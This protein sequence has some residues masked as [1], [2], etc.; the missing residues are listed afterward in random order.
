MENGD[1]TDEQITYSSGK[2]QGRL[3]TNAWKPDS[4]DENPYMTVSFSQTTEIT[5]I[6]VMGMNKKFYTTIA[7]T[8]TVDGIEN[9][10]VPQTGVVSV[11]QL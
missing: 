3:N 9:T 10:L 4:T 6:T 7:I 11:R 5:G 1:I 8:Y 2:G